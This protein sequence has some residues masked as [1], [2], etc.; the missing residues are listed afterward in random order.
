[1]ALAL[2]YGAGWYSATKV[3]LIS[4]MAM[5]SLALRVGHEACGA[6]GV[7]AVTKPTALLQKQLLVTKAQLP[8][9]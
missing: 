1:M 2:R 8:S 5:M 3:S 7:R 4:S 9:W 6:W